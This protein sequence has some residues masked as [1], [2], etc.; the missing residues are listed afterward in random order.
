MVFEYMRVKRG[1]EKKFILRELW[2][3][4]ELL[5]YYFGRKSGE[6]RFVF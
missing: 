1:L 5:F 6:Y 4:S 2:L 3:C